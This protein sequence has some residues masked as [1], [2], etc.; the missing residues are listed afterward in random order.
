MPVHEIALPVGAKNIDPTLPVILRSSKDGNIPIA[1]IFGGDKFVGDVLEGQWVKGDDGVIVGPHTAIISGGQLELTGKAAVAANTDYGWVNGQVP[2]L[3][4]QNAYIDIH[5]EVP[6]VTPTNEIQVGFFLRREKATDSPAADDDYLLVHMRRTTAGLTRI[7]VAKYIDNSLTILYNVATVT[8]AE[9]TFRIKFRPNDDKLDIY[10]HDG[11]GDIAESSDELTLLDDDLD[12]TFS[13]G[14]PSYMLYTEDT[15]IRTTISEKVDVYYPNTGISYDQDITDLGKG[16]VK[17]YDT[18]GEASEALWKRVYSEDHDFTGDCV[19]EN[20]LV[21]LFV[22]DGVDL[23]LKFYYWTGSAWSQPLD[24]IRVYQ[25]TDSKTLTYPFLKSIESI[26]RAESYQLKVRLCDSATESDDYYTEMVVTLSRGKYHLTFEVDSV[27]PSQP[28]RFIYGNAAFLRWSYCGDDKIGDYDLSLTATNTVMTDN[29]MM[30]F[31]DAGSTVLAFIATNQK[32]TSGSS[33]FQAWTGKEISIRSI[34]VADFDDTEIHVGLIPF[35]DV[36]NLFEEAEDCTVSGGAIKFED[37]FSADSSGQ[38][39]E[40]ISLFTWD[41]SRLKGH[42]DGTN[43]GQIRL[44]TV[45]FGSGDY[46]CTANVGISS[47]DATFF[48]CSD[49]LVCSGYVTRP[50][51]GWAVVLNIGSNRVSLFRI[52]DHANTEI[53]YATMTLNIDTD[54]K[55]TIH[56][57]NSA[58]TIKVDIDDVEKINEPDTSEHNSGA[59]GFGVSGGLQVDDLYYD[60]FSIDAEVVTPTSSGDGAAF[61][62]KQYETVYHSLTG[63]TDIP[64]GRYLLIARMMDLEQVASDAGMCIYNNTESKY[65]NEDKA[66]KN[67]T[68]TG[69]YAYYSIVFDVTSTDSGDVLRFQV[70]KSTATANTIVVDYF[71]IIP[72]TDGESCIQDIAHNVMRTLD[73]GFRLTDTASYEIFAGLGFGLGGVIGS[74]TDAMAI[75]AVEAE[76]TLDL[77]GI[78]TCSK[79]KTASDSGV[80]YAGASDDLQLYHDGTHSYIVNTEGNLIL[81]N[82]GGNIQLETQD[83]FLDSTGKVQIR[84]KD[85][86]DAV[87]FELDSTARTLKLGTAADPL[88]VTTG[89][90][91]AVG[92]IVSVGG[93]T[94][95]VPVLISNML[96]DVKG[97]LMAFTNQAWTVLTSN[98]YYATGYK[99][100]DDDYSGWLV[101]LN[102]ATDA[103]TFLWADGIGGG[104]TGG[105]WSGVAVAE[106]NSSGDF[107]IDGDLVIDGGLIENTKATGVLYR[108]GSYGS[109]GNTY[110][111][112]SFIV[113]FNTEAHQT[114]NQDPIVMTTHATV[115][116]RCIRMSANGFEFLAETGSVTAGNLVS[117]QIALLQDDGDFQIDGVLT[118]GGG[119]IISANGLW[120][121]LAGAVDG[122]IWAVSGAYPDYG[123]YYNTGSPDYMEWHWAGVIKAAMDMETGSLQLDGDL[124]V[125]GTGTSTFAG[126][127]QINNTGDGPYLSL[128][129]VGDTTD[130]MEL[131]KFNIERAWSFRKRSTGAST[132]LALEADVEGKSFWIGYDDG[133]IYAAKFLVQS[134]QTNCT[135]QLAHHVTVDGDLTVSGNNI[136]DSGGNVILSSDGSGYIDFLGQQG[137]P[138]DND[139]L[140]WDT[141]TSKWIVQAQLG[142][143]GGPGSG[144]QWTL[145]VWNT[146]TTLG[147]S[148][149]KQNSGGTIADVSGDLFV[150]GDK[151]IGSVGT[152]ADPEGLV[153]QIDYTNDNT[154][155]RLFFREA[156]NNLYGASIIY[157]ADVTPVFDGTTFTNLTVANTLYFLTHSNSLIGTIFMTILRG[158]TAVKFPGSIALGAGTS[159]N[160]IDIAMQASPTDNQLLTAQ[161]IQE[162]IYKHN[163]IGSGNSDWINCPYEGCHNLHEDQMNY[164]GAVQPYREGLV[165]QCIL[166]FSVPLP[167]TRGGKSLYINGTRVSLS[168][169]NGTNRVANTLL[170]GMG[171]TTKT[172]LDTDPTSKNSVNLWEDTSMGAK[173][174]GGYDA[175]KVSL[176]TLVATSL[177]LAVQYVTVRYYY[178]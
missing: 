122:Y 72:I 57:D 125:S 29:F 168:K 172:T 162:E 32:P 166:I 58:D 12:L 136:K 135:V 173:N 56:F 42:Y 116:A 75:A 53:A 50:K 98:V 43:A 52:V 24:T 37:D 174:L 15:T 1:R 128:G 77:G 177:A 55:I 86:S 158:T 35:A 13:L 68:L 31:D 44:K 4:L 39:E 11:S 163:N 22:D 65:L 124:V 76:P 80:F 48:I 161:A 106:L 118:V 54:Y 67:F 27:V 100:Y 148:M 175:A 97:G 113:G 144:T 69:S 25:D 151:E 85:D 59:C 167:T 105:T 6:A 170:F 152:A 64:V 16:D 36:G 61:L 130:P 96:D 131:L 145:P 134:V 127:V 34:A 139:V 121:S 112:A 102:T 171:N 93:S 10:F 40:D 107:Q 126:K 87:L 82:V 70:R 169:A 109:L 178:A 111:G 62:D 123:L 143:G 73:Q 18:M 137:T 114:I 115:G 88:A 83:F 79:I 2:F 81:Q 90:S 21:R 150:I 26:D 51:N 47:M 154:D 157:A 110:A 147:D 9:G 95:G 101:K 153:M 30:K 33:A 155:S 164:L 3:I 149:I 159:V 7:Y 45:N 84:D 160:D 8:N 71:L 140:A 92:G 91:V 19:I 103:I 17:C 74:Y 66:W 78:L 14:Y 63:I 41:L 23:G 129:T 38:Y 94:D 108:S 165:N 138:S 46:E 89:G 28:I 117:T 5:L 156:G 176:D 49:R 142:G 146:T 133:A 20:G 119:T 120:T 99:T 141:A 60:D 104:G 132:R